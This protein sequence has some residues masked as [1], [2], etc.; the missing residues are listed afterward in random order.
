M[1]C[2]ISACGRT[3]ELAAPYEGA[4]LGR[5]H[6]SNIVVASTAAEV[7]TVLQIGLVGCGVALTTR[8]AENPFRGR[9]VAKIWRIGEIDGQVVQR[10]NVL[11]LHQSKIAVAVHGHFLRTGVFRSQGISDFLNR[12]CLQITSLQSTASREPGTATV[13]G[14]IIHSLC[15]EIGKS[16]ISL[17]NYR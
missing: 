7:I 4:V 8:G 9:T 11:D 1:P 16:Y 2:D 17:Y 12:R 10:F 15:V 3:Y 5:L 14:T 13:G 6:M